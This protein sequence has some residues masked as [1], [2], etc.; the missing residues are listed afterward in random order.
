L[1]GWGWLGVINERQSIGTSVDFSQGCALLKWASAFSSNYPEWTM[2]KVPFF[3]AK[4]LPCA[5]LPGPL[6]Q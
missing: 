3:I 4:D 1:G 2:G 5:R 6:Y